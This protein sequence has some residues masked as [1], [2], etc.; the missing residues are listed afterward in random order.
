MIYNSEMRR[1]VHEIR[2]PV[3]G[4]VMHV[5]EFD[6]FVLLRFYYSQWNSYTEMQRARCLEYLAKVRQVLESMGLNVA[7][8]PVM[9]VKNVTLQET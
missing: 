5:V 8:D 2:V 4:F 3:Q 6:T 1:A 9:D 7:L